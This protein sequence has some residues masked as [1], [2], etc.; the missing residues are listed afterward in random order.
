ML[1]KILTLPRSINQT[2][3]F[4]FT[5]FTLCCSTYDGFSQSEAKW[6]F[7]TEGRIFGTPLIKNNQIFIGSGDHKIYALDLDS[8]VQ[9]WEFTTGGEVR[10]S[11]RISGNLILCAS[12]DGYLYALDSESGKMQWKFGA[13]EEKR[14]GLWDYYLSSP[15][16]DN[17]MIFWGSGDGHIYAI[18]ASSGKL[19]WKFKTGGIVHADPVISGDKVFVG[20]FDG[21]LYALNKNDGQLIWKFNTLGAQYFPKGEIQK[22]VLVDEGTVYFGSRDYNL[23][24]LDELT[25]AVKWNMR[26]P[27]GWIVATPSVSGDRIYFGTS[28][29]HKFYCVNKYSGMI[30][31]ELAVKM[32][33]YG[34]AVINDDSVYF[35]TFDGKVIRADEKTGVEKW[36]FQ[37][38]GSKKNYANVFNK[39]G[40]FNK[41]FV[42]YGSNIRETENSILDL[43]A[44][45]GS[46]LIH[47]NTIYFGSADGN[48]Y[49]VDLNR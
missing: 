29:A 19:K 43:G 17:D 44:I 4:L 25:G 46:P 14:Y 45:L 39:E 16:V 38:D 37:T 5:V 6:Q 36:E 24:A 15:E 27:A 9:K 48:L 18:A 13:E 22:A 28:D 26:E 34:S 32:R 31:W 7:K 47:Q 42:L 20:S 11:P 49:A 35:G 23:Y 10:S 33:V 8:G 3:I 40:E 21:N 30:L 12:A 2:I 41:D 1:N